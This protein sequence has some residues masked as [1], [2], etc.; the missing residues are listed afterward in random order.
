MRSLLLVLAVLAA[1]AHADEGS[2][3]CDKVE[4]ADQS[5][6]CAAFNRTTSER[7]LEDSYKDLVSRLSTQYANHPPQLADYLAKIKNAQ[8]IWKKLRDA[9]CAV[10]TVV[11]EPGSQAFQIAQNDC[12]S[13]MTDERSEYLQSIGSE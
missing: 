4:T 6:A 2:T 10:Q 11:N 1:G 13:Q 8:D 9:D 12:I 5:F 3:P 7:Q